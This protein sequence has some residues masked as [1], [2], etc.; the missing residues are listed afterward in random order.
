M[1]V[2]VSTKDGQGIRNNDFSWT[3]EGELVKFALECDGEKI[4]GK[5]GCRRSMSGF[6]T[7]KA[8]TT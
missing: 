6:D 1:K 8:T 5:C 4:D 3:N 2:F 7:H